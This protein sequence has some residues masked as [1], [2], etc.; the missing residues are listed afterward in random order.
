MKS[1]IKIG[2]IAILSGLLIGASL[3]I[4]SNVVIDSIRPLVF[5]IVLTPVVLIINK[6]IE[7]NDYLDRLTKEITNNL[8]LVDTLPQSL[9]SVR[10]GDRAWLPGIA[11][12]RPIPGYSLKY[13]SLNCFDDFLNQKYW[14]YLTPGTTDR[15]VQLYH[16]FREY[17]DQI[18]RLQTHSSVL[19]DPITQK[20]IN[21]E[22]YY[23][24][25]LYLPHLQPLVSGI[26]E[27][28]DALNLCDFHSFKDQ[29]WWCPVWLKSH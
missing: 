23:S 13:L 24:D 18:Q 7:F 2:V 17:C 28:A 20:P 27:H 9:Q 3:R 11:S 16:C 1:I 22:C 8:K 29:E 19:R 12:N 5:G 25:D 10:N 6:T 14:A 4:N 21:P 15:L 26:H